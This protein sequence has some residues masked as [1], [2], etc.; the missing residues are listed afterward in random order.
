MACNCATAEQ[1]EKLYKKYGEKKTDT[2]KPLSYKIQGFFRKIGVF[3]CMIFITP[4]IFVYV[5]Y[6][7]FGDDNHEISVKKFFNLQRKIVG[8]NVG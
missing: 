2:G 6:K 8:S 3:V 5:L 7:M 1:I 4:A